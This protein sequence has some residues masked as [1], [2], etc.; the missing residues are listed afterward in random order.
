M[1]IRRD[2]SDGLNIKLL[3][4]LTSFENIS[5]NAIL[6]Q[7][8]SIAAGNASGMVLV[9]IKWISITESKKQNSEETFFYIL[10]LLL[11]NLLRSFASQKNAK[12]D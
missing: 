8:T 2:C 1:G 5:R 10:K 4:N 7:C 9:Q 11:S 12:P 6:V 3:K